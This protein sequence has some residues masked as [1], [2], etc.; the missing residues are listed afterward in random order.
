MEEV[1][2]AFGIDWRLIV[3]QMFNFALLAGLLWY[4]LYTPVL[5]LLQDRQKKIEKGVKDAEAAGR[6]LENAN[7]KRGE[8]LTHAEHEA[9]DIVGKASERAE[10]KGAEILGAAEQK[11]TRVMS[12][13]AEK[14]EELKKKAERESEAEIAKIAILA[15]EK[16]LKDAK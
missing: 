11:A 3:I 5:T 12:D 9:K 7:A 14:A 16:I 15:A 1:L 6:E 2:T 13:A 8:I 10:V 4:F